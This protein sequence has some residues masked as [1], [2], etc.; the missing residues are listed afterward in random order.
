VVH[1]TYT[2]PEPLRALGVDLE[3]RV[4]WARVVALNIGGSNPYCWASSIKSR[5]SKSANLPITA[6]WSPRVWTEFKGLISI[7]KYSQ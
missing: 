1:G 2:L 5:H 4:A 7:I 3:G 6:S